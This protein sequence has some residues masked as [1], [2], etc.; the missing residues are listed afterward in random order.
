[1][2]AS[3]LHEALVTGISRGFLVA[4]GI[5]LLA[6][7]VVLLTIRIKRE[8]IAAVSVMPGAPAQDSADEPELE[9]AL[10]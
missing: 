3:I 2:P 7:V 10:R 8:D 5:A 4:S 1:M 6:L 9:D